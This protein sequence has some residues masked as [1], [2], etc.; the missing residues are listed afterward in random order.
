ME[1]LETIPSSHCSI[2]HQ[3]TLI[4]L[5]STDYKSISIKSLVDLSTIDQFIIKYPS[6]QS[7][8][9]N[10]P[11]HPT[12]SSTSEI[13][14]LSWS[15]DSNRLAIFSPHYN[16][17]FIVIYNLSQRIQT[18]I[19]ES[20]KVIKWIWI[21]NTTLLSQLDLNFG[22]ISFHSFPISHF[23]FNIIP[24]ISHSHFIFHIFPFS[25][26]LYSLG[27]N[28]RFENLESLL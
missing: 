27:N 20:I 13:F 26:F 25:P 3:R 18:I 15:P 2:N 1:F 6:T 21:T 14:E 4:A 19:Q 12:S 7:S 23:N 16:S 11:F 17:N 9:S 8:N 24:S 5:L 10:L 22:T 28:F